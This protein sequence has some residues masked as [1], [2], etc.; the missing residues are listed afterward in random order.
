M[1]EE[2]WE[3]LSAARERISPYIHRTPVLTS[4]SIDRTT[5]CTCFFK[6]ENFQRT[7]SFKLRG[8]VNAV[9]ALP[10]AQR[11]RG[12]VTHS[13]GNHGQALA[14]AAREFGIPAYVV[15]PENA[16]RVKLVAA[17][18]YGAKVV[19]CA[20]TQR[21][22]EET[23]ARIA[24]ETGAVLIDSHD[25]PEVIAGQGTTA[26]ELIEEVG[27]LD[28][29]IVPIGGGGLVSGTAV[30]VRHVSP[31][32]RVIGCEPAGAD[33]AYRGIREGRRITDFTPHT[34]AD[35]LR[36]TI[37]ALNFEV[38]RAAVDEIV[39]VADADIISAMRLI[40]AR[41]KIIVEP[42]SAIGLAPLITGAL[43][44]TGKRV[45]IILTGGNVDLERF[46]AGLAPLDEG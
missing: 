3:R 17:R 1:L 44:L 21:A 19:T 36:T 8:A 25:H 42:S 22:R 45:G 29:I 13:S 31:K 11:S 16:P 39:R 35:G 23:A 46:F 32:T 40:W 28:A 38:I 12:V 2:M 33:D 41:M 10:A 24:A 34:I 7:G 5:G 20:P 15:I 18:D 43:D 27:P 6:C 9:A 26:L 30:A 14:L 4:S 37:G